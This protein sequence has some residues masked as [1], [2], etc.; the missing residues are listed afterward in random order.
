MLNIYIVD[1]HRPEFIGL[2]VQALKHLQEPYRLTWFNNAFIG[3]DVYS[4]INDEARNYGLETIAV[5]R[6]HYPNANIAAASGICWAW[7]KFIAPRRGKVLMLHSDMFLTRD[8]TL[9]PYTQVFDLSY[10]AQA[11][12]DGVQKVEYMWD[13]LFFADLDRI[14]TPEDIDWDCGQVNDIPVDVGGQTARY[15]WRYPKLTQMRIRHEH[16]SDNVWTPFHPS[17]Y[18]VVYLDEK[19]T[20]LHYRS[21]SNWDHK[22]QEYHQQKVAWVRTQI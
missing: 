8:I 7:Q 14:P 11:K 19:P 5:Q 9:S 3:S 17:N 4:R 12:S 10:I 15:L 2:Q 16:I 1:G 21:G 18:E 22:S 6:G 20:F 13:S